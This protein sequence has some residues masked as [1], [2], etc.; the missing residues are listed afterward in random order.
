MQKFEYVRSCPSEHGLV[1]FC[2][3]LDV[4]FC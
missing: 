2:H 1:W 4:L 3:C